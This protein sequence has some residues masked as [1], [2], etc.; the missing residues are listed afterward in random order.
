MR[1]LLSTAAL[2][3][4]AALALVSASPVH[5][6]DCIEELTSINERISQQQRNYRVSMDADTVREI[7]ELRNAA[8]ILQRNGQ[9]ESCEE[10][11]E[12]IESIMK[13]QNEE[14]AKSADGGDAVEKWQEREMARLQEAKPVTEFSSNLWVAEIVGSDVRN[15]KNEDLGEVT[16]VVVNPENGEITY[17]VV[18][19]GGFLGLGEDEVAVPWKHLHV[20]QDFDVVVLDMTE[21]QLE[22]APEIDRGDKKQMQ[23]PEWREQTNQ[24]YRK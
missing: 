23:D 6:D 8:R 7:R 5:A 15:R 14:M 3:S 21:E 22:K 1:T 2:A 11:V 12:S 20:T 10:V 24:Y 19:H 17:A 9:E 16:D 4:A 18:T 13:K